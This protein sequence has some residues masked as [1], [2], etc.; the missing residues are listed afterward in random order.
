M[1][2][3]RRSFRSEFEVR[4]AHK[5]K[6]A[7][8]RGHAAVFNSM[9][10]NLGGFVEM[11][12]PG[13]FRKTLADNP[14]T[15]A[16]INHD[17][18]HI[19]GRTRSG[20]L[21]MSTDSAGL[22]YEIDVPDRQDARDLMVSLER[23]DITQSSFSFFVAPNGDEW[24]YTDDGFPMRTLRGVSLHNGDVSVVTFP[25]YE[26]ADSGMRAYRSFAAAHDLDPEMVRLAG[27]NGDLRMALTKASFAA[28]EP[29]PEPA[30]E[31]PAEPV[32]DE[33]RATHSS[34]E[35]LSRAR[36]LYG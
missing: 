16:L 13:A 4:A 29:E 21:R 19:M 28:V 2:Q 33:Q 6:G 1:D 18:M 20:T 14:D 17:P 27:V 26:A 23:G 7:V 9:S 34:P 32:V 36:K 24:D 5:G 12:D 10:R 31:P 30:P 22:A 11:V 15:R 25:A 3:E 8:M 35:W